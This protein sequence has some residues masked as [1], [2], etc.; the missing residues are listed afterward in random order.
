ML[1]LLELIIKSKPVMGKGD[2][3]TA[4]GKRILGS[5]GVSRPKKKDMPSVVAE[6]SAK[7]KAVKEKV[8]A[9]AVAE[10]KEAAPKKAAVKKET[11]AK[12]PV[13]EKKPAAKK[14]TTEKEESKD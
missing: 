3:K 1:Y 7:P 8:A 6:K 5:Y 11:V 2:K 14:A 13:A 9:K 12:K 4:K 10:K